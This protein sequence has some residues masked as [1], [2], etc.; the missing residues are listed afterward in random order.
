MPQDR[1][2]EVWTEPEPSPNRSTLIAASCVTLPGPKLLIHTQQL[3][4]SQGLQRETPRGRVACSLAPSPYVRR[5]Q[6]YRCMMRSLQ[7]SS[8]SSM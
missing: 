2:P 1:L 3:L 5:S 7:H 8:T 4:Q 6:R